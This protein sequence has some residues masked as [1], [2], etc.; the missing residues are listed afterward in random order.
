MEITW[1]GH[2]FF[3]IK[4]KPKKDEEVTIAIDPYDLSIG[5]TSKSF[6]A[7]ILL[8]T[9]EHYDHNNQKLIEGNPFLISG[10]GEYDVKG[11]YIEGIE[12]Y[13]DDKKGSERGKITMYTIESEGLRVCHLSD[14]GQKELADYQLER[15]GDVDIL[16]IPVGGIYTISHKEAPSIISQIEPKIVIPM[17]Y[18][19][20]GLRIKLDGVDKFL[21]EMGIK[22]PERLKR[23]K[24][25]K[26]DLPQETKI[27]LLD[28][29]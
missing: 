17:H 19:L 14:L 26:K 21:K 16:L 10:P 22:E 27:I 29:K 11:V 3:K 28:Y 1:F 8:I 9:H 5:L 7:D 4:T 25:K 20:P 2:A 15:I 18:A 12:G 13:H 6:P 24:I 23:L